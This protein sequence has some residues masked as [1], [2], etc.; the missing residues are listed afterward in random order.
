[1]EMS[2]ILEYRVPR[3][4]LNSAM[5]ASG[6]LLLS[7][8]WGLSLSWADQEFARIYP[9]VA[10]DFSR[11]AGTM[12]SYSVGEWG[13][14]YYLRRRGALPLPVDTSTVHGGSFVV[15]LRL[16]QPH[17]IPVD[18]R[19]FLIPVK[20]IAYKPE[21]LVRVFDFQTP[22]GFYST[23]WGLIP[24]SFS[25]KVL[26]EIEISQLNFVAE[27]LPWAQVET[28]SGV[29]PW[30]GYMVLERDSRLSVLAKPG[31]YIR[32]PWDIR[33]TVQLELQFGISQDSYK[34]GS[35]EAF[36]FEVRQLG[37]NGVIF[38]KQRLVLH[39]GIRKEDRVW[40]LMPIVLKPVPEGFLDFS[41]ESGQKR[42]SGA[43]AI[44]QS[45]IR[46]VD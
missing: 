3:R 22:A 4:V 45:A 1:L 21:T 23:G 39:P 15:V 42:A 16:A 18:L 46:V 35:D 36:E 11:I 34:E 31:T 13:F 28:V 10:A 5:L 38:S 7:L 41:F 9:R 43:G 33:E 32:Y 37:K 26:E 6:S 25:R 12:K 14:R 17:V 29:R 24:F 2:E 40:Q 20:T 8:L 27:Q 19:S 44:T 30:P